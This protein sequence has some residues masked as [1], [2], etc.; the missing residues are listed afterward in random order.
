LDWKILVLG[1]LL[2][3]GIASGQAMA[4]S[5]AT[6]DTHATI[7]KPLTLSKNSDLNFGVLLAAAGNVTISAVDGTRSGDTGTLSTVNSSTPSRASFNVSGLNNATYSIS[8]PA[9]TITLA[10]TTTTGANLTVTLTGVHALS[11]GNVAAP[12]AASAGTL[13]TS[14]TDILGL[15]GSLTLASTTAVGNYTNLAG[16]SLTVNY[17]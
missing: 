1:F 8:S 16:I 7:L 11:R 14:G 4:Q 2:A 15:G 5:T 12:G 9:T 3:T 10:N 17:N 6:A 13:S